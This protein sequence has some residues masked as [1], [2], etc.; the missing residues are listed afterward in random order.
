MQTE[1]TPKQ[2][3][4][5]A[6]GRRWV[7]GAF[8]GGRMTSYG[9]ALLL[10]EA[11]RLFDVTGRLAACFT[12]HRDQ[13]RTKHT[14]AG[15][16]AQR[17]MALALGHEDLNDHGRLRNGPALAPASGCDDLAGN[18]RDRVHALTASNTLSRLEPGIA[19][20]AATDSYR[21]IVADPGRIDHLLVSLFLETQ[22]EAPEENILDMGATDDPIHGEQESRFF[23]GYCNE[24]CYLL[25]FIFCGEKLRCAKLRTSYR[26]ASDGL[27]EELERIVPRLRT[28]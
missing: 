23:H 18:R 24:Y 6:L 12:D 19:G 16:I 8:E 4:F 15:M 25:L 13:R 14:V 10:R 9:G 11:D 2:L 21:R 5:E 28:A 27:T 17:V 7:V 26:D 22:A 1:F 3:E 20:T